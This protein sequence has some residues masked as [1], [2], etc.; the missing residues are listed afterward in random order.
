M[1]P[2]LW[3]KSILGKFKVDNTTKSIYPSIKIQIKTEVEGIDFTISVDSVET[4]KLVMSEI[5]NE[6]LL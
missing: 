3:F 2:H 5:K 6:K 1:N 4:L